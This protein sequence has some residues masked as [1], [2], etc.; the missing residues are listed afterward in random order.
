[1]N[2]PIFKRVIPQALAW[3]GLVALCSV[4]A[5]AQG[6]TAPPSPPQDS[7]RTDGQIEMDVVHA[8][9]ASPELK[10]DLYTAVTIQGEVTLS[11][12]VSSA[13][14]HDLA[15]SIVSHVAGVTKVNNNLKV[16]N[17]QNPPAAPGTAV[18]QP[19]DAGVPNPA[20]PPSDADALIR[21]QIHAA[22]QAEIQAQRQARGQ[23]SNAPVPPPPPAVEA[24]KG[25]VTIP[26]GTL[27]QLRTMESV[28]TKRAKDGEPVQFMVIRDVRIDGV[29]AIPRG[30]TAH[31][32]VSGVKQAGDLKGS[33]ELALKLTSLDM[34][35]QNYPLDTGEFRVK[36]P[37]KGE[38]SANNMVGS[39]LFGTI[40]GCIV[41]RGIGCAAGAGA[42]LAA[43][44]AASAGSPGPHVWI[45]AEALVEFHLNTPLTVIPVSAKEAARLSEGLYPGGP[46][47]YHR[48]YGPYGQPYPYGYPP[49]IYYHPYVFS[50]GYYYWR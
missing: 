7:V 23:D 30:A 27:L 46:A 26:Q 47:L 28:S 31:G 49:P 25:P 32:V 29:V 11:G 24:P 33:P 19:G 13:S 1:M 35:G 6:T 9:D 15:E 20:A 36:G 50:D 14:N 12:T 22:V 4:F 45:P 3:A 2:L 41:G 37:G 44:T 48:G 42:G 38:R 16:G 34:G 39:T 5:L 8:L 18:S 10:N 17:P 40:I 21:A 43:G